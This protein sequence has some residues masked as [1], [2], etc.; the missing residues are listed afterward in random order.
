MPHWNAA[1]QEEWVCQK[2]GHVCTGESTW[3]KRG[4][5][6]A[7]ELGCS[8]NVCSKCLAGM[9]GLTNRAREDAGPLSV[10]EHARR[11][12]GLTGPALDRYVQRFY[13]HG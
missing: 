8:G 9:N 5:D 12:S 1:G 13:G 7:K 3:V 11:E 10:H 6:R 4:S 2:G